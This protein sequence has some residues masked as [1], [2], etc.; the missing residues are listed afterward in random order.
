MKN[1]RFVRSMILALVLPGIMGLS[2]V[3]RD[4]D[5][6][7][8]NAPCKPGY[9]CTEDW[10]CV[11]P[12]SGTDGLVAVDS[13]G[14]TDAAG[15]GERDWSVC[16]PPAEMCQPGFACT[17]DFRCVPVGGGGS[18]GPLNIDSRGLSDAAGGGAGSG[19]MGGFGGS[20]GA[21]AGPGLD[22]SAADSAL[23]DA[24][25]VVTPPDARTVDL[26]P[27]A[28]TVDAPGTCS[29]DKDCSSQSPLCLD[30]RCAK[31]AGDTD[32]EGRN[33]P[34]C[35]SSGLC[36]ACT[37]DKHCTGVAGKC[38]TTTNQCV[39]CVT[40][41]DCAGACQTCTNGVCT[42]I[43]NQDDSASCAGT[44]DSTG[45]CKKTKGQ[46]CKAAADCVGGIPCAD[47]RCC[48]KACD[49]S[50]EACDVYGH[51]GTCTALA[52]G[53]TPHSGHNPCGG[54]GA[55]AGSCGGNT[56][57]SCTYPTGTCGSANCS[58]KT[59]QAA[60]TCNAGTCNAP[61]QEICQ[62]LC[63]TT[64][65]CTGDCS[66]DQKRCSGS[67]PQ[68]CDANGTWQNTGSAC[69]GCATCSPLT[70]TCVAG[71]CPDPDQCHSAGTCDTT[72][73]L[74]SNPAKNTGSC[75]DG[76]AC[77][78]YD[79]CKAGVC[80][81]TPVTCAASTCHVAGTC[82][83]GNCPTGGPATDGTLDSTCPTSTP[84]CYSG[85]CVECLSDQH[86][87]ANPSKPSCDVAT[88]RCVCR[89]PSAGNLVQNPGF[90]SNLAGWSAYWPPMTSSWASDDSEGCQGS[91]SIAGSNTELDPM[92]C[93][94][95]SS[96][97]GGTYYFGAKFKLPL[98]GNL[99]KCEVSFFLDGSCSA[100][101]SA[102]FTMGPGVDYGSYPGTGWRNFS[103][104][105]TAPYGAHSA[106]VA[107]GFDINTTQMD[108]IYLNQSPD[109][110]Y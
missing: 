110:Q 20:G 51:L 29:T 69:S 50:C 92:Q 87:T 64:L 27:D 89:R 82:S 26:A 38:D 4:W 97:T 41:S 108:E 28:P 62:F 74:C 94:P 19:G 75:N 6:C 22:G 48:D 30:N 107:C 9:V 35:T 33:G 86:C 12:D 70:G 40:R 47:G 71:T 68:T 36:V 101:G 56:D 66:L 100:G 61:Y 31:C 77:T 8:S 60:G 10:R 21:S 55:C 81:G 96:W 93:V 7:A 25:A 109:Q 99:T 95:L 103:V 83:A 73:G 65:G 104:T 23:P 57:G 105:A 43:K 17:A 106:F 80:V 24:P 91:G 52:S 78:E 63:S 76:N 32:C 5:V 98:T 67:Q 34:A 54:T 2:C 72:T 45:A 11:L 49:G 39:G 37:A 42:A 13:H 85:G 59:Y 44:C 3:K 88:H 15:A 16:S 84:R 18:D 102:S 53:D 1:R 58:G 46:T 14:S 79:T 90:D